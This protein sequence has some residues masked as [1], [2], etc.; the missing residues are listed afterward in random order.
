MS[1]IA[2]AAGGRARRSDPAVVWAAWAQGRFAFPVCSAASKAVSSGCWSRPALER[3]GRP[4][5]LLGL[6]YVYG[7]GVLPGA[8]WLGA[9]SSGCAAATSSWCACVV[10]S[11]LPLKACMCCWCQKNGA[12][13]SCEP[14]QQAV[15][16]RDC[17][18]VRVGGCHPERLGLGSV[19]VACCWQPAPL[20]TAV[21]V[22]LP[23]GSPVN[24]LPCCWHGSRVDYEIEP[25]LQ[26]QSD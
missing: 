16:E 7:T 14:E 24:S 8:E 13:K 19:R 23:D 11:R 1:V 22:G 20:R 17:S 4:G 25:T 3:V 2:C 26:R 9:A 6:Y 10:L 5:L 15:L 18:R 12:S 21:Y